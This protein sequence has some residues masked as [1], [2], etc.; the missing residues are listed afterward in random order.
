MIYKRGKE[1]RG[2][3]IAPEKNGS[4][5]TGLSLPAQPQIVFAGYTIRRYDPRAWPRFANK[6]ICLALADSRSAKEKVGQGWAPPP[7]G[8]THHIDFGP[9]LTDGPLVK[10]ERTTIEPSETRFR[11]VL[12]RE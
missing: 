4:P 1:W 12:E 3:L 8:P 9:W 10:T 11:V 2:A 6:C 5:G 7:A